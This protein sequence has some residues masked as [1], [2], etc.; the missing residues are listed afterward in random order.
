[1]LDAK[2]VINSTF[3][4]LILNLYLSSQGNGNRIVYQKWEKEMTEG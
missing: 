2:A 1:M 4:D 3:S